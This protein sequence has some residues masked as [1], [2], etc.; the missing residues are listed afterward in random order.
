VIYFLLFSYLL[1]TKKKW[2]RKKRE[3]N[4]LQVEMRVKTNKQQV[5]RLRYADFR[6]RLLT[7]NDDSNLTIT[8]QVYSKLLIQDRLISTN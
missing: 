6:T 1:I 3:T 7:K 8:L 2:K 5:L 4:S